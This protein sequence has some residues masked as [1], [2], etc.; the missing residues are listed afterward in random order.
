MLDHINIRSANKQF[1]LRRS[2]AHRGLELHTVGSAYSS[3][4]HRG[5]RGSAYSSEALGT[6]HRGWVC[7]QQRGSQ[8]LGTTHR[9]WVCIQQRGSQRL[10]TTHR[11][12]GL[13][14]AARRLELHTVGGSAYSS[15]AFGTTHV[16]SAYSSEVHSSL[17]LHTVRS[18]SP[19]SNMQHLMS[20]KIASRYSTA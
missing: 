1:F 19:S 11:G 20:H 6:T 4:A 2:E 9:G 13:H 17:E 12:W 5:L 10:G 8:R 18:T 7:I 16:G 3:E 14:T 15:E